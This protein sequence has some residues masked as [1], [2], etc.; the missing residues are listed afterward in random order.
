MPPFEGGDTANSMAVR[1][2]GQRLGQCRPQAPCGARHVTS[3]VSHATATGLVQ[4]GGQIPGEVMLPKDFMGSSAAYS[5][6]AGETADRCRDRTVGHFADNDEGDRDGRTP[7]ALILRRFLISTT[8]GLACGRM[9]KQPSCQVR[10]AAALRQQT[11]YRWQCDA[12][13]WRLGSRA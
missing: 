13:S 1:R 7:S 3:P 2:P 9:I 11:R 10:S 12:A 6:Q 4:P 8:K 5:G